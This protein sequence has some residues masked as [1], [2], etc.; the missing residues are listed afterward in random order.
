MPGLG[1]L[2]GNDIR[3][4]LKV[5]RDNMDF[6]SHQKFDMVIATTCN[7]HGVINFYKNY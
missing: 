2:K 5:L 1:G 3:D 6:L 7:C 4:I